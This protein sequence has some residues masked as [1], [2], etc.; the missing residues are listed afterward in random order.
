MNLSHWFHQQLQTSADGFLWAI[1]QIPEERIYLAPRA[2]KWPVAR[3]IYHLARYEQRLVLPSMLQWTGG[4][5]PVVGTQQED[6][7][8]EDHD[9]H[10]GQDHPIHTLIADFQTARSQQIALLA[11]FDEQ[12]WHEQRDVIWGHLPL[13]WV[14]TKTY[15]HTLEH[16]DEVLRAYLWW[17]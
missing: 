13:K 1:A 16:T 2:D 6:E 8:Q 14:V 17:R 4:P 7:A 5:K 12:S 3:L 15:Q 10:A 9:W 11:Q